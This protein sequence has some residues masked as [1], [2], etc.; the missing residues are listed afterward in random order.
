VVQDGGTCTVA[1]QL[2]N[3]GLCS[4]LLTPATSVL[5]FTEFVAFLE[6]AAKTPTS[7]ARGGAICMSSQDWGTMKTELETACRE[8]GSKCSYATAQAIE[9]I[10]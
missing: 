8:L 10:K 3:G 6:P 9:R 7:P 4:H 5:S 1:G 2:Q